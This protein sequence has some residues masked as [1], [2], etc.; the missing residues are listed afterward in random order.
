MIDSFNVKVHFDNCLML[1]ANTAL[2][3]THGNGLCGG[4]F[5][6]SYHNLLNSV[7]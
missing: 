6:P 5:T 1:V 4:I 3:C 7:F 2:L